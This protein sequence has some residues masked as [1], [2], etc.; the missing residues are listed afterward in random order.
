MASCRSISDFSDVKCD[1]MTINDVFLTYFEL[2]Y[3]IFHTFAS[4]VLSPAASGSVLPGFA[5]PSRKVAIQDIT[6][7]C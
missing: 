7:C 5:N 1:K 4:S 3:V 2:I 6:S